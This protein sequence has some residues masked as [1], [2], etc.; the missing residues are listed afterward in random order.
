MFLTIVTFG[1]DRLM[2]NGRNGESLILWCVFL[3][4]ISQKLK[5]NNTTDRMV[6]V[7]NKPVRTGYLKRNLRPCHPVCGNFVFSKI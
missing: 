1:R 7:G 6:I 4:L 2:G 5:K 3:I